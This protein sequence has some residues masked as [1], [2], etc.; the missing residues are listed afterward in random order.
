MRAGPDNL[1]TRLGLRFSDLSERYFPDALVFAL[2]GIVV[3]F[4]C[5]LLLGESPTHLAVQGGEAF[6]TLVPFTMQM[7]MIIVGGYVVASTPIVYRIIR[8]L[9]GIPKTPRQAVALIALFSML[10]S[11]IH[12]GLSLIIGGLLVRELAR[13][14]RVWTIVRR[15]RQLTWGWAQSGRWGC[16]LQRR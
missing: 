15:A 3:V 2:L 6:W 11:V 13:A 8:A 7:V 4:L 16:L 10:A 12:W 5:G 9:A 14:S 1:L